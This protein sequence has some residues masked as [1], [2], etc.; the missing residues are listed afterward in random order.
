MSARTYWN[1][2]DVL[3][4]MSARTYWNECDVLISP[5]L[6]TIWDIFEND[7]ILF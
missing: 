3:T 5:L 1:E 6:I 2:Y 4:L 7:E